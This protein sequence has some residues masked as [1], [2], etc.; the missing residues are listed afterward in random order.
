M[1][2]YERDEAQST[3]LEWVGMVLCMGSLVYV[4]FGGRC[5][6]ARDSLPSGQEWHCC[7]EQGDGLA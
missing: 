1:G 3:K 2:K 6:L 4:V 5:G 7:S